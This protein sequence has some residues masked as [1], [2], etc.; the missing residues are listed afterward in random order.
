M[1]RSAERVWFEARVETPPLPPALLT[2]PSSGLGG[3]QKPHLLCNGCISTTTGEIL[4]RKTLN[5]RT[6]ACF[7]H[8]YFEIPVAFCP[9]SVAIFPAKTLFGGNIR[10]PKRLL[11]GNKPYYI[12]FIS[13]SVVGGDS[14]EGKTAARVVRV[15][16]D[17]CTIYN[18]TLFRFRFAMVGARRIA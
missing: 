15:M 1:G 8:I 16:A 7:P 18:F 10:T 12:T 13:F 4:S 5:L 9:P 2:I 3:L 6:C 11:S 17:E 14:Q